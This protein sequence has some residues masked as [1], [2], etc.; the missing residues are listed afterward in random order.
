MLP[1]SVLSCLS[2]D[3]KIILSSKH[4]TL[5]KACITALWILVEGWRDMAGSSLR[6][7]HRPWQALSQTPSYSSLDSE[8]L[9]SGIVV[10]LSRKFSILLHSQCRGRSNLK[11]DLFW[12]SVCRY[13]PSW[14]GRHGARNV[15]QPTHCMQCQEAERDE[16]CAQLTS[17]F[18]PGL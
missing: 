9:P 6:T 12:V 5:R 15:R 4:R 14:R 17:S 3:T 16:C 8:L 18:M 1:P 11:K 7:L 2:V 10:P 13:Y